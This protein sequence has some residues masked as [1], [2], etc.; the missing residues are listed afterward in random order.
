[1]L[2]GATC[3]SPQLFIVDELFRGT[4]SVERIAAGEAVV[5]WLTGHGGTPQYVL[6]ATH[7]GELLELLGDCC[8]PMHFE[9]QVVEDHLA[10]DYRLRPGP[11]TT[12]SA[13]RLLQLLGA[14]AAV[15]AGAEER[16]RVLDARGCEL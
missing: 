4:N 14:P 10:F 7:D 5:R 8:A 13:L 1:M 6:A 9:E 3:P 11:A 16:A 12:R 15:V 2:H